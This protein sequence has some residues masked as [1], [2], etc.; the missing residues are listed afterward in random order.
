MIGLPG[1]TFEEWLAVADKALGDFAGRG[2][3]V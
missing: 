3:Q 2:G 1:H